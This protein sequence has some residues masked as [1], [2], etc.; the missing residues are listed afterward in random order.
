MEQGSGTANQR[1][2]VGIIRSPHGLSGKMKVESTSGECG[3]FAGFDQVALRNGDTEKVFN[4]ESVEGS[5]SNLLMKCS[6]IDSPEE[7]AKY[8]NWEIVVPRDKACPL[9][10]GEFYIEDLKQCTLIYNGQNGRAAKTAPTT[11]GT[12]TSVTEGGSG[13]L[14]EVSLSESFTGGGTDTS[15]MRYVPFNKEFIGEVNLQA[16]TVELMHLWVL[17]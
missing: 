8:R 12:I 1:F 17:E 7:A 13:Y 9:K 5:I 6:G 16:A 15:R 3:H 2:V 10:D 11:I 14:L 4:V